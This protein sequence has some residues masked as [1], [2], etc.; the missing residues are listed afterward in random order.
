MD[1]SFS[2]HSLEA[3]GKGKTSLW[4]P[5]FTLDARNPED[6]LAGLLVMFVSCSERPGSGSRGHLEAVLP[7]KGPVGRFLSKAALAWAAACSFSNVEIPLKQ[8]WWLGL[9]NQ[10]RSWERTLEQGEV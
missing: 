8:E 2:E 7:E 10:H 4:W 1:S 6:I 5:G 3:N 9:Q